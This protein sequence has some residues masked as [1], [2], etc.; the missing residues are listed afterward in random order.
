MRHCSKL[1]ERNDSKSYKTTAHFSVS[2]RRCAVALELL[3][4]HIAPKQLLGDSNPRPSLQVAELK[5][6]SLFLG[7]DGPG[8]LAPFP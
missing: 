1:R 8:L 4:R 5:V 2:A 6:D 7:H 3:D